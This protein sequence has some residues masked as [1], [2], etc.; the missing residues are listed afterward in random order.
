MLFRI[1]LY[2]SVSYIVANVVAVA[3]LER[4]IEGSGSKKYV[5]IRAEEEH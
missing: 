3:R 2:S 1:V 4:F 5:E